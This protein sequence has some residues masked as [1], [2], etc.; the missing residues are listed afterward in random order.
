MKNVTITLPDDL[1]HWAKVDAAKE[2]KSLS[3]HLAD[4]LSA[5]RDRQ[6][7][8]A[9]AMKAWLDLPPLHLLDE[10]GRPPTREEIYGLRMGDLLSR[11]QH[12]DLQQGPDEQTK[13]GD[14]SSLDEPSR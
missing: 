2:G 11:H 4:M 5:N 8:Q 1:A 3:R 12:P 6:R 13:A 14:G 7:S 9:A 10:N